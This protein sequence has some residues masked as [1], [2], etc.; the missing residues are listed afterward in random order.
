MLR[1]LWEHLFG[2]NRHLAK[3]RS[4][5]DG[6]S[7]AFDAADSEVGK[8][9]FGIWVESYPSHLRCMVSLKLPK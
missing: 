2:F 6:D 4:S 3:K 5:L 8:S 7:A 1:K 9:N